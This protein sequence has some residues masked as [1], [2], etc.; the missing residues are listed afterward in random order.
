[1]EDFNRITKSV[2]KTLASLVCVFASISMAHATPAQDCENLKSVPI[3]NGKVTET[4]YITAGKSEKDPFRMFTGAPDLEFDLPEHCLVRGEIESRTNATGKPNVLRFEVRLPTDWQNRFIFQGGGGTDGFLANAIG[5][6]PISG[7]TAIPALNR[8]YAVTSMN[9]GHDGVDPTFGLDQQARLDYAYAALGKVTQAAK[10]LV[11]HYYNKEPFYS[12]FMGCSNGGRE[13]MIAAQRYPNEYNGVIAANP[14]F[15]LSRAAISEVWDTRTLMSIAPK[16][17]KGKKVLA[18][19]LTSKELQT[20]SDAVL[21]KCDANDG[22]KD[23]IIN[24]YKSCNFNPDSL[25]CKNTSDAACLS[26]DKVAAVKTVFDGAKDSNGKPLYSTWPYDAGISAP[27]WRAWKLGFSQDAEKADALNA[28]LGAGSLMF[29]FMTPPNPQADL[30]AFDFDQAEFLVGETGALND[31]TSTMLNTF[32]QNGSKLMIIQ[33]VSDPV[34]SA[35]DIENWY[36]KTQQTTSKGDLTAMKEW[37]RLFMVP[38][39]T[40]CGGG[41]AL[42]NID[43]LTAMQ[44]WVE[45]QKAPD[46]LPAKGEAFPDKNMP[47]CSYPL[48]AKYKGNGDVNALDS[49]QCM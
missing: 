21:K 8:G 35:D 17:D 6:T 2:C 11:N 12:Y 33:G 5:T 4:K 27:G 23:G 22:I 36:L 42:D 26:G 38:G 46:Y 19:A 49:Y 29:Y 24:D 40:H 18:N 47:I 25:I 13:A 3:Y 45:N 44:N 43:P 1:M 31:A 15:H 34:F 39:M 10:T 32:A 16:N 14:G 41:P 37:N 28:V 30:A 20:L 9:G 48:V 7:S